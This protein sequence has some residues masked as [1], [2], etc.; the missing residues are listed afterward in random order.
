MNAKIKKAYEDARIA[1]EKACV[2]REKAVA[3][4][5]A[6]CK[7]KVDVADALVAEAYEAHNVAKLAYAKEVAA[8]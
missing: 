7:A 1:Y 5:R 4:Y 3:G 6:D 8:K 2:E